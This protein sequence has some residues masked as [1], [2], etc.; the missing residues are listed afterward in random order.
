MKKS[1]AFI[2]I[3]GG[4]VAVASAGFGMVAC[5][6]SS[7]IDST[8]V[9]GPDGSKKDT[10]GNNP[11][12]SIDPDGNV[13]PDSSMGCAKP[14]MLF[15][16][17]MKGLYCP[18]SKSGD[19]GSAYCT[20]GSQVCCLSP[21][22]EAGASVCAANANACPMGDPIWACSAPEECP[23]GN[24]CCLTAGP[25]VADPNCTGFLKTKGF[26][27]TRCATAQACT[28][29]IDAGKFVDN[30]YVACTKQADCTTGTCTAVKT[31]GTSIGIC[32]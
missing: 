11:D 14:P 19:A 12:T 8:I 24:V 20:V 7:P 4:G 29:T 32:M 17:S 26:N 21:S 22:A 28:G 30:Q 27:N 31:S 10:G 18:F 15:P 3:F 16:P 1:S 6:S 25:T 13:N 9:P 5:T 2:W 23:M